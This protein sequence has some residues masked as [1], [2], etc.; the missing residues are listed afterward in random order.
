M[1]ETPERITLKKIWVEILEQLNLERG[2]GYTVK[3]FALRPGRAVQEYL[4]QDRKKYTK[5][6]S[7]L[8][9]TTAITTFL[10]LELVIK[11]NPE[12]NNLS[13]AEGWNNLPGFI[14]PGLEMLGYWIKNY[15]N[16]FYL[17][18]LPSVVVASYLVFKKSQPYNLAEHL[19]INTYIF[20]IQSLL[21]LFNIPF[22]VY[23][24]TS[25]WAALPALLTIFY[26]VFAYAKIF[27]LGVWRALLF[28][29]II[30]YLSQM[31][32][33]FLIG[34]ALVVGM[35]LIHI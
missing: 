4:Y 14:Q 11:P 25:G 23:F 34:I 35:A 1:P 19:V 5:P 15:F 12:L 31:I 6:F 22:L 2:L 20:S 30:Y 33:I 13:T 3:Q 27:N 28:A 29:F 10:V 24:P 17:S 21:Y 8:F 18:T 16:L 7:F 26:F 9:L 32:T